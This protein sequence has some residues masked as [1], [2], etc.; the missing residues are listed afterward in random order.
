MGL[1]SA[2]KSFFAQSLEPRPVRK[3]QLEKDFDRIMRELVRQEGYKELGIL[4]VPI[5]KQLQDQGYTEDEAVAILREKMPAGEF[6][7]RGG[8]ILLHG[9]G[10]KSLEE[11][12][13]WE[14]EIE[15]DRTPDERM[16]QERISALI[17]QT[18]GDWT[19]EQRERISMGEDPLKVLPFDEYGEVGEQ[20]KRLMKKQRGLE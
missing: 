5:V 4:S 16:L 3:A 12:P 2:G 8:K 20:L 9:M 6:D 18:W 15:E 7:I 11:M 19:P 14:R 10:P 13:D 17:K 1:M